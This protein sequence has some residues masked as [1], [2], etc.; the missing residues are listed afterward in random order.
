MLLH[1]LRR[2][3]VLLHVKGHRS[4]ESLDLLLVVDD[5]HA[6]LQVVSVLHHVELVDLLLDAFLVEVDVL[7]QLPLGFTKHVGE[8]SLHL[9][10]DLL[11]L[12]LK[13]LVLLRD[14][15]LVPIVHLDHFVILEVDSVHE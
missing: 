3:L 1:L 14:V 11:R 9:G 13:V 12:H 10:H 4:L 5:L 15:V 6:L 8:E 2:L 7:M